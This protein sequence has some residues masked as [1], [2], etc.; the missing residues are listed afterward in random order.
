MLFSGN[1]ISLSFPTKQLNE[2]TGANCQ[3]EMTFS[4][5]KLKKMLWNVTKC[6]YQINNRFTEHSMRMCV[7]I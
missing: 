2:Y 5:I 4:R 7:D 6:M 3:N 1:D